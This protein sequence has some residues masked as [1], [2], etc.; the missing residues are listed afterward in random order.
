MDVYS[1]VSVYLPVKAKVKVHIQVCCNLYANSMSL[2]PYNFDQFSNL[3][4]D[5]VA[6]SELGDYKLES[7]V[8]GDQKRGAPFSIPQPLEPS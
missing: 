1:H 5:K 7:W 4:D 2:L 3:F 6:K 8:N